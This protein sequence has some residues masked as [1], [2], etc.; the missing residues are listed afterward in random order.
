MELFSD[1]LLLPKFFFEICLNKIKNKF[2]KIDE[3]KINNIYFEIINNHLQKSP[4]NC[5]ILKKYSEK[6]YV[7]YPIN[8]NHLKFKN[9]IINDLKG[10]ENNKLKEGFGYIFPIYKLLD[11]QSF[12]LSIQ[13]NKLKIL[14][15][16]FSNYSLTNFNE[17][18]KNFIS[19]LIPYFNKNTS[20]NILLSILNKIIPNYYNKAKLYNFIKNDIISVNN[21]IKEIGNLYYEKDKNN[22]IEIHCSYKRF[23]KRSFLICKNN[24]ETTEKYIYAK[25]YSPFYNPYIITLSDD[26]HIALLEHSSYTGD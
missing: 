2:Y 19:E 24:L 18:L 8:N 6:S 15:N 11:I 12:L 22:C 13:K 20:K 16:E 1:K 23:W 21:L 9:F 17:L 25:N 5:F 4:F 26:K 3:E 14:L 7:L 10:L